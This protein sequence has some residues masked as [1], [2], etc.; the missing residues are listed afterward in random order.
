MYIRLSIFVVLLLALGT[1][2]S[3]HKHKKENEPEFIKNLTNNQRS[4]F[5]A[6]SK[7]P[8]FSFQQK[9]DKLEKWA[10][11]NKL[12]EPYAEFRR[13]LS[14]HKEQVSKNVSAAIDRLAEAKAE[15][16]KVDADFSLT[17]IQRDDKIEELK[18]KYP[19]EI[20]TLFYMRSL[21]E[22]SKKNET[23]D[24]PSEGRGGKRKRQ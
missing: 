2:D 4:S 13:N 23:R 21:F 10:E 11:D 12:S 1:V 16:D 17:K 24:G 20:P 3:K 8:G 9:D 6:I 7:N 22:H 14:N 15:V 18:Q 5:F 19:Q